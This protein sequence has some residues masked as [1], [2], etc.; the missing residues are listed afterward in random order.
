MITDLL[1][2]VVSDPRW[3]VAAISVAV[4]EQSLRDLAPPVDSVDDLQGPARLDA[5]LSQA[6]GQPV[7][8]GG[9]LLGEAEPQPECS[10]NAAS[11]IQV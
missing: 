3:R 5:H 6:L 8:E 10:K 11:R 4:L 7:P 9:R 2:G 1:G